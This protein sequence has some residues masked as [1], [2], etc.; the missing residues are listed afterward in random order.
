MAELLPCPFCGGKA[1]VKTVHSKTNKAFR[2]LVNTYYYVKC[3]TCGNNTEVKSTAIEAE[4]KWNPR[5]P[6]ER[7]DELAN[8]MADSLE[9]A[10]R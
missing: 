9:K 10:Q 6:K 4:E 2:K 7:E 1:Y 3:F 8:A 5:T